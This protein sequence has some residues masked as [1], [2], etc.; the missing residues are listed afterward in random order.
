M[1]PNAIKIAVTKALNWTAHRRPELGGC[2]ADIPPC[3]A[4][5]WQHIFVPPRFGG[6]TDYWRVLPNWPNSLD[7][8]REAESTMTADEQ[9][10]YSVALTDVVKRDCLT[11][12]GN[13]KDPFISSWY[14][15]ASALQRCEAF[16][17][18][19]GLWIEDASTV[20]P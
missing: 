12:E 11:A 9:G 13:V 15:H 6:N 18:V 19:K 1:T 16:L 14:W 3:E 20:N 2:G 7:H 8:M 17:R 4:Y 10:R 5:I